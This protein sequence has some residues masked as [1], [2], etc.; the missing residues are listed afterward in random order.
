M[1][2][3]MQPKSSTAGLEGHSGRL[4]QRVLSG[5]PGASEAAM[6]LLERCE[7]KSVGDA[8]ALLTKPTPAAGDAQ[9]CVTEAWESYR[10]RRYFYSD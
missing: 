2:N 1:C 3:T 7:P 10:Y 6:M 8:L 4:A 9:E 5:G